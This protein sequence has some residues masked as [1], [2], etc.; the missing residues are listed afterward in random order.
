MVSPKVSV[1][2]PVYNAELYICQCINSILEQTYSNVEILA[3]DDGSLDSSAKVLDGISVSDSRI[4]VI[5]KANTGVSDTRNLGI[6]Q[7]TGKFIIFVDADDYWTDKNIL[8]TLVMTAMSNNLDIVR[9]E[10][11][12]VDVNG[13]QRNIHDIPPSRMGVVNEIIDSA[14]FLKNVIHGEYFLVLSLIRKSIIGDIRFNTNRVFLE[15]A[16]F[17]LRLLCQ[18]RRCLYLPKV[19]YAYRKHDESITMRAHPQKL[20]DAF[21]FTRLCYCISKNTYG[22]EMAKLLV[23]EG[24]RNFLFDLKVIGESERNHTEILTVLN[25]YQLDSLNKDTRTIVFNHSLYGRYVICYL[26]VV[27]IIYYYRFIYR[28]KKFVYSLRKKIPRSLK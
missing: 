28:L 20:Y 23:M 6:N 3:I 2:I 18:D 11:Q 8:S 25:D 19:F 1:I 26:P 27:I 12:E 17:Y 5:H 4:R 9:A 14:S 21:D 13:V 7:A 15:D 24:V 10:Y 16:E 22:R